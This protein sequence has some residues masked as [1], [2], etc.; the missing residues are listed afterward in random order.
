MSKQKKVGALI[1]IC[2]DC[3]N[4]T[5]SRYPNDFLVCAIGGEAIYA[6]Y[7]VKYLLK[8]DDGLATNIT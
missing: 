1:G 7:V 4:K 2:L 8:S 6:K 5:M 3:L